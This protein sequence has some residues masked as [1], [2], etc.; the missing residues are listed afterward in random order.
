M[1]KFNQHKLFLIGIATL[2]LLAISLHANAADKKKHKSKKHKEET[3][4]VIPVKTTKDCAVC[5]EMI[6]IPAGS[7]KMGSSSGGDAVPVH[8]VKFIQSFELGKTEITQGQWKAIMGNNPSRFANSGDNYPVERVSWN[9]AQ[10][11]IHKL[12]IKTGK[13]YRLPSE[14]E[15]EYACETDAM[16]EYCG[17]DNV[18]KVA[19]YRNPEDAKANGG[20][21]THQVATKN[22]NTLGLYDM[23][24]NVWE[25]VED[26]YHANYVGAPTDGS[27]WTGDGLRRVL[28]GGSWDFTPLNLRSTYRSGEDP[29]T[30]DS[31]IGF[32]VARSI[33]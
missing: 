22:P 16:L 19:W 4:V 15:W 10:E 12:N 11:F 17:D 18:D 33:P 25:W 30:R 32:R 1:I 27:A 28:R 23:S 6:V 24:G 21:K 2:F 9:D 8:S 13:L 14:A 20:T 3:P 5:P 29:A 31:D 26:S 7:Y